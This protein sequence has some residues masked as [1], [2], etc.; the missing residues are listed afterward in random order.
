[1]AERRP[2]QTLVGLLWASRAGL[3]PC[4]VGLWRRAPAPMS[5]PDGPLTGLPCYG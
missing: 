4:P 1:M 5:G 3:G 2:R